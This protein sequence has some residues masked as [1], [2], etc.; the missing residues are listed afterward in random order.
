MFIG[1]LLGP[2][3]GAGDQTV[4][5]M[6]TGKPHCCPGGPEFDGEMTSMQRTCLSKAEQM[7]QGPQPRVKLIFVSQAKYTQS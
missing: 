2:R 6:Q 7:V 5:T 3:H 1:H 4:G